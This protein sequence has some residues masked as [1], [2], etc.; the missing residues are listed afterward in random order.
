MP[1]VEKGVVQHV[2]VIRRRDW[3]E[4]RLEQV[5]QSRCC[6]IQRSNQVQNQWYTN[7]DYN[8]F[9]LAQRKAVVGVH[10]HPRAWKDPHSLP[11]TLLRVFTTL[12]KAT[13]AAEVEPVWDVT[14]IRHHPGLLGL[15]RSAI[16]AILTAYAQ[17]RANCLTQIQR[18]QQPP[19]GGGALLL[20]PAERQAR[21][22]STARQHSRAS[23]LYA[24]YV[25]ALVAAS[26]PTASV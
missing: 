21:I 25:G 14:A 13:T 17:N 5:P 26:A 18:L 20:S 22:R 9:R 6:H 12:S 2:G 3:H 1:L 4:R 7:D 24:R 19:H 8:T 23:R 15:E 16:P 11:S 10:N